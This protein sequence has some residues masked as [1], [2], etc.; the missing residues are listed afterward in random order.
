MSTSL[1]KACQSLP[2]PKQY[3]LKSK[4]PVCCVAVFCAWTC[5]ASFKP[6]LAAPLK[7][8]YVRGSQAYRRALH[9]PKAPLLQLLFSGVHVEETRNSVTRHVVLLCTCQPPFEELAGAGGYWRVW[10]CQL[11]LKA[12]IPRHCVQLRVPWLTQSKSQQGLDCVL[13][14][15][16]IA[17]VVWL[18]P[19]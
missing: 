15:W 8:G 11:K 4:V 7:L 3:L 13:T 1:L 10:R 17:M 6:C 18:D 2:S 16:V 19:G 12:F 9:T 14:H 5:W